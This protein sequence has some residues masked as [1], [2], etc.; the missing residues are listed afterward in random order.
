M[1]VLDNLKFINKRVKNL[2][3]SNNYTEPTIIVV[4]KTFDINYIL[5]I[6]NYGHKHFGENKVQESKLKWTSIIKKDFGIKLHMVGSLQ[7]NKAAEAV[8]IFNYIHSLDNEKLANKLSLAE[9]NYNKKLEYFIQVNLS[10]EP[11]KS[12]ISEDDCLKFLMFC[13]NELNLNIIGLMCLPKAEEDPE[14]NFQKLKK[15]ANQLK[16]RELSMGMSHDFEKAIQ[17]GSSYIRIGSAILGE[18]N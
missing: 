15:L 13:K 16:L 17:F 14:I 2:C 6:I 9:K 4:S 11:Q 1:N 3:A 12:G 18:R 10:N 8:N 5:P 7:S